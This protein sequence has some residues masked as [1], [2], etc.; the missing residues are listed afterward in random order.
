MPG[1]PFSG[2]RSS[3]DD[4]VAGNM[5]EVGVY[6]I[7]SVYER[8]QPPKKENGADPQVTPSGAPTTP[9]PPMTPSAPTP[10]MTPAT[11][12]TPKDGQ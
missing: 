4:Q 11:P 10:P 7:A 2:I 6:G 1:M 5:V 3:S 9:T 8:Y 12:G